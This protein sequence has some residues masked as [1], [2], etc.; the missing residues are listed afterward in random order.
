ML[1]KFVSWPW[2]AL[3]IEGWSVR[4]IAPEVSHQQMRT[5]VLPNDGHSTFLN[6]P[7]K[8]RGIFE[9]VIAPACGL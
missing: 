3:G 5:V 6:D 4:D 2:G 7:V 9:N 8:R 1:P